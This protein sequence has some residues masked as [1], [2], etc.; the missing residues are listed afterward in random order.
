MNPAYPLPE[1]FV[2]T[3]AY[4]D[5]RTHVELARS[6]RG[7]GLIVGASGTGKSVA[8]RQLAIDK[9]YFYTQVDDG[10][11]TPSACCQRI[12]LD[13]GIDPA[14]FVRN[15]VEDIT[16]ILSSGSWDPDMQARVLIIDEMQELLPQTV[17]LLM[18]SAEKARATL[19]FAGNETSLVRS[20]KTP[21]QDHEAITNRLFARRS[22]ERCT[23][24]DC[25]LI[26]RSFRV[27]GMDSHRACI[28]FGRRTNLHRLR[29][30]LLTAGQLTDSKTLRL[31]HLEN[32]AIAIGQSKRNARELLA[33]IAIPIRK[34]VA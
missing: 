7:H 3:Q 2:E 21:K 24:K 20:R 10:T 18:D 30:L 26:A 8:L 12:L 4:D 19:I 14:K 1:T 5:I 23:E 11:K 17:K 31:H 13:A 32:A 25:E 22:I 9:G 27:E 15:L 34:E 28:G 29:D 6:I 16:R 33:P